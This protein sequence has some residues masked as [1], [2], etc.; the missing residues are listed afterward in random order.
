MLTKITIVTG[1]VIA[2]IN[3]AVLFGLDLSPDQLAGVTTFLAAV[4]GAV[5]AWFNPSLPIGNT[6]SG[7][8]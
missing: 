5:H 3:L 1:V 2:G 6:D 4:G 8:G 7:T